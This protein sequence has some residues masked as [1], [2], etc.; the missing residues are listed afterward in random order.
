MLRYCIFTSLIVT[1]TLFCIVC[2]HKD[3]HTIMHASHACT[4]LIIAVA[5]VL[6][7]YNG[8][9]EFNEPGHQ[10]E[11]YPYVGMRVVSSLLE[12]C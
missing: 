6:T 8:S 3:T 4:Q 7:G 1:F 11:D 5:G 10:Y 12:I 2:T 9:F